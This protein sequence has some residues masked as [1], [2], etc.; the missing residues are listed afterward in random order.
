LLRCR[1]LLAMQHLLGA[2]QTA[3]RAEHAA[4]KRL[5]IVCR[6][7]LGVRAA[8]FN[9]ASWDCWAADIVLLLSYR[10]SCAGRFAGGQA[11]WLPAVHKMPK[12]TFAC[13][14]RQF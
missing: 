4:G 14:I 2:F 3:M 12:I 8:G 1:P 7:H 5:Y 6:G 13:R 10:G 9:D 11:G